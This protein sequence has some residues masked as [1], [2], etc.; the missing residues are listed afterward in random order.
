[1]VWGGALFFLFLIYF[2]FL[3]TCLVKTFGAKLN[4]GN[5]VGELAPDLRG[6]FQVFLGGVVSVILAVSLL[7]MAF[8]RLREVPCIPILH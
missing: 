3:L 2:F 7:L 5:K 8:T 4:I 1:M 6:N